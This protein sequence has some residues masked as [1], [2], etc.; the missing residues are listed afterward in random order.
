M[1]IAAS[2]YLS[3]CV[4]QKKF[5]ATANELK[6][7]KEQVAGLN[8]GTLNCEEEKKRTIARMDV[9][10]QHLETLL[11][12]SS[13]T[14]A[15]YDKV[16]AEFTALE[17]DNERLLKEKNDWL[18]T[19]GEKL[20]QWNDE[21]QQK[22]TEL[23]KKQNELDN[24]ELSIN[25]LTNDVKMRSLRLRELQSQINAKDSIM[26]ALRRKIELALQGFDNSELTI[27][28]RNGKVYVSMSEKLLFASG[29]AEID[30]KGKE[31]LRKLAEVLAKNPDIQIT[32]EGHTDNA[33]LKSTSYPRNNWD[34]SVLR[35][36]TIIRVLTEGK[37]DPE[38]ITAAGRGQYFPMADNKTKDGRAKNRRTEIIL[39]PNLDEIQK[40]IDKN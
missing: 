10:Q 8:A 39:T 38:R 13:K 14:H 5:N 40:L 28:R 32:V 11:E 24:K 6:Q 30:V 12:D 18:A 3:A 29:S 1:L 9:L 33:E 35:S 19:A 34:L 21:L 22:Q 16:S 7:V 20:K 17:S 36:T 2:I 26:N 31:A 25:A 23:D 4:S 15:A 27:E 37:I